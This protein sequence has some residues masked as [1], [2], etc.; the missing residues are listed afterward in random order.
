MAGLTSTA[1]AP[2]VVGCVVAIGPTGSVIAS[3]GIDAAEHPALGHE[4]E[5]SRRIALDRVA[6]LSRYHAGLPKPTVLRAASGTTRTKRRAPGG[7]APP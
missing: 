5:A 7:L 4:P 1:R 3:G 6:T 2:S